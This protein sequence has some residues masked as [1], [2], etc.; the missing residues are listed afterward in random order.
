MPETHEIGGVF[1][2]GSH[3]E[4]VVRDLTLVPSSMNISVRRN[5]D[6][7]LQHSVE[8]QEHF[9][10]TNI[11]AEG[12][13]DGLFVTFPATFAKQ[14]GSGNPTASTLQ[15]GSHRMISWAGLARS[16]QTTR[17]STVSQIAARAGAEQEDAVKKTLFER[18]FQC[19]G[20]VCWITARDAFNEFDPFS[21]GGFIVE[22]AVQKFTLHLRDFSPSI[23]DLRVIGQRRRIHNDTH[24][25]VKREKSS[26][27]KFAEVILDCMSFNARSRRAS[28]SS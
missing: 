8:W 15:V 10:G 17:S 6:Y 4:S 19:A 5:T 20:A 22:L 24:R 7:R 13:R 25:E 2:L 28:I 14:T 9:Y 11:R 21:G 1:E 26:V 23:V 16:N 27:I 12:H 18:R 3:L